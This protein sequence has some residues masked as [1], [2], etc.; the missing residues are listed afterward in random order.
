MTKLE[1]KAAW[2]AMSRD[3]Q[4]A[5]SERVAQIKAHQPHRDVADVGECTGNCRSEFKLMMRE[6]ATMYPGGD[7]PPEA[8]FL[9]EEAL[10]QCLD[11]CHDMYPPQH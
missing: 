4:R 9:V 10:R 5:L 1:S 3:A 11:A 7:V 2:D 8:A 6:L